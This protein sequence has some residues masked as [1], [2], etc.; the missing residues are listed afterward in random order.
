MPTMDFT[1]G[2]DQI[3][4]AD[5]FVCTDRYGAVK[6]RMNG[7]EA[8]PRIECDVKPVSV[9]TFVR[10]NAERAPNHPALNVKREMES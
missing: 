2:P 8:D 1:A 4:P 3:L 9:P 6:L 7:E 5:S 10:L